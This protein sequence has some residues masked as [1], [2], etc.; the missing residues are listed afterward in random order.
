LSDRISIID[1]GKIIVT[2][3]S[4]ELKNKLGK[5]LIYLETTDNKTT[6]E[7]LRSLQTVESVT[8]DTKSLRV[9]I[10]EDVTHVLPQIMEKIRR[11]GVDIIIVNIKKPSMDDVFVH[12]TG[13][14]LREGDENEKHQETEMMGVSE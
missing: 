1:H 2:G 12:Y 3:T 13:H 8:E 9:M 7:I 5:D 6:A 4:D 10:R 14:G 11:A